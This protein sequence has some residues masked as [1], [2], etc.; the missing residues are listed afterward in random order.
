MRGLFQ[1]PVMLLV[2]LSVL[3]LSS[4]LS[5]QDCCSSVTAGTGG[6]QCMV[7]QSL[8]GLSLLVGLV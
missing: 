5:L 4:L 6:E 3:S 7:V 8:E 2:L 1:T